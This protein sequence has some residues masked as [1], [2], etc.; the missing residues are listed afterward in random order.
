MTLAQF[1]DKYDGKFVEA[2]GSANAQ[3]QCVDLANQYLNEVLG[4]PKILGTNAIDFPKKSDLEF[5]KNTPEGLPETGDLIVFDIKP[6]GHIS[7]FVEG[8]LSSFKSFDQN[9]PLNTPCHLQGHYYKTVVGWLRCKL[10]T[11]T[12]EQARILKFLEEQKAGEGKV[13]E[14]FGA[15][16]DKEHLERELSNLRKQIDDLKTY[17]VSMDKRVEELEAKVSENKENEVSWQKQLSIANKMIENISKELD[18][19]KPFKTRYEEKCKETADKLTVGEAWSL[20]IH[21][22][23]G[24]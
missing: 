22:L 6:Y 3:N 12:E 2:G 8:T 21:K 13:R 19:Y 7:I 17:Q 14:A 20:F 16:A 5:I 24:K 1:I 10:N 15:L 23:L 18:F 4:K 11:M 9:Y